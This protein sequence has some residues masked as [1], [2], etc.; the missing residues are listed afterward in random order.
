[1]KISNKFRKFPQ[2]YLPCNIRTL[3]LMT[4]YI[5]AKGINFATGNSFRFCE[6]LQSGTMINKKD[7][8]DKALFALSPTLL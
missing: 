5:L 2:E 4:R 7:N 6:Q 8:V 1:M 3:Y